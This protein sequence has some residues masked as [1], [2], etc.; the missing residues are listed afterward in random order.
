MFGSII[1]V[2]KHVNFKEF[3]QNSQNT[4][5]IL[6]KAATPQFFGGGGDHII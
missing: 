3:S 4:D 2:I 6:K 1:K 5:L